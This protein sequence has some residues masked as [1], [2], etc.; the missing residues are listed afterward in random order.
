MNWTTMRSSAADAL[1]D[2]KRAARA[3]ER[4]RLEQVEKERRERELEVQLENDARIAVRI[5]RRVMRD[6]SRVMRDY[7]PAVSSDAVATLAAGV[8]ARI[9]GVR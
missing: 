1:T 2:E 8:L 9:G 6:Y 5:A 4:A 7:S 3:A